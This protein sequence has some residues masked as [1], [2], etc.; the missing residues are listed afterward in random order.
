MILLILKLVKKKLK[1]DFDFHVMEILVNSWTILFP[2]VKGYKSLQFK[3]FGLYVNDNLL[4]KV[5]GITYSNKQ[6]HS[7][8]KYDFPIIRNEL[9]KY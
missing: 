7:I 2:F 5:K 9:Q 8:C 4:N 1:N 6:K 3:N